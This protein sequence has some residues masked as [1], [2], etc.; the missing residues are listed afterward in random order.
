M[1][2]GRKGREEARLQVDVERLLWKGRRI[3]RNSDANGGEWA[4]IKAIDLRRCQ[5]KVVVWI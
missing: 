5:F 4:G 3:K 1:G 2:L